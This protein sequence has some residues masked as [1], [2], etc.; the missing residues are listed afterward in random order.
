MKATF[1]YVFPWQ[2]SRSSVQIDVSTAE[3]QFQAVHC[4][5]HVFIGLHATCH[6]HNQLQQ[7]M[8]VTPITP[9]SK[10]PE[11]DVRKKY[12]LSPSRSKWQSGKTQDRP[13]LGLG[14]GGFS[15]GVIVGEAVG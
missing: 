3:F 15:L 1:D 9:G 11:T 13:A 14:G 8:T 6:Q 10:T 5:V 2:Q 7:I 12:T 4:N